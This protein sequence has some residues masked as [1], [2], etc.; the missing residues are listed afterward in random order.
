MFTL[1]II[2]VGLIG[3]STQEPTALLVDHQDHAPLVLLLEGS[4]QSGTGTCFRNP[5]SSMKPNVAALAWDL[6]GLELRFDGLTSTGPVARPNDVLS[7]C[8]LAEMA[9]SGGDPTKCGTAT[10]PQK[11]KAGCTSG[12]P[13][14]CP[15]TAR[16]NLPGV[17]IEPC[18]L[19]HRPADLVPDACEDLW[20]RSQNPGLNEVIKHDLERKSTGGTVTFDQVLSN[21]A[22]LELPVNASAL[23]IRGF[24]LFNP[25]VQQV[26]AVVEPV[27]LGRDK[28]MTLVILNEPLNQQPNVNDV[29]KRRDHFEHLY[30]LLEAIPNRPVSNPFMP[31]GKMAG[32]T[33]IAPGLCEPYLECVDDLFPVTFV[34]QLPTGRF[35]ALALVTTSLPHN[36]T[37]CDVGS[38]P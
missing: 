29:F 28:V 22:I 27:T 16:V 20:Q 25:T 38:Y 34:Q 10:P 19:I 36:S 31:R 11:L 24:D 1:R 17:L 15:L 37:A 12:I 30:G 18:H 32:V 14:A 33:S 3:I 21:A 2:L 6:A 4:C 35:P 26:S 13:G 23:T 7:I 8:A 9:T 5:P